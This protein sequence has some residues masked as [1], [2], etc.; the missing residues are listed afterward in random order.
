MMMRHGRGFA[1]EKEKAEDSFGT[2]WR[3]LTYFKPFKGLVVIVLVL[4]VV[5]AAFEVAAPYLIEVAVDQFIVPSGSEAPRWLSS[6]VSEGISPL[7]GLSR[8]MTILLGTYVFRWFS[9][10]GQGYLMNVMGQKVLFRMRTQILD[11]IHSLSLN[12]F[13][14][15]EAGDLMSRLVNDT[16]VINQVFTMGIVRLLSVSLNLIGIVVTMVSRKWDLALA[17]F[18]I[19]PVMILTTTIFAR[20]ARKAF[21][22]TRETIG[23]VSSELE[24]NISGV[25]EVQAFARERQNVAEFRQINRANR[26]ANVQAQTLT[27]AFS[28]TLDVLSNAAL[29]IVLGYGGWSVVQGWTSVGMVVG[30]MAYVQRFYRP[31]QM[32]SSLWTMFQSALAGAE[33]IFELLDTDPVVSDASDAQELA[34]AQGQIVFDHVDFYYKPEDPV[35]C[36]V[37]LVAEP[38]QTVALVGPTGAGKTSIVSLLMRFYDVVGGSVSV[39]GQDIRGVTQASLREQMGIV[40]QDT[41]LFSGTVMDNIR[42]GRLDAT[43]DEVIEASK[44]ANA[45][46]FVTRLP[47]EYNTD[48]GERGHNLSQGQ[49]QLISIARAILADPRILIL[50][51]ATSSVDTRTELLIQRALNELLHGRTSFVIAHRLSTIR[52]ADQVLFID[53]GEIVERGTHATLMEAGGKYHD[54]YMSQFRREEQEEPEPVAVPAGKRGDG[55][56]PSA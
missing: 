34:P 2:L 12:F 21:R 6:I 56:K 27:S 35:L 30:Y 3:L 9:M 23:E 26:D 49:R 8:V 51:E 22:K 46:D 48:I 31:I 40:L 50:D 18:A 13:D 5:N 36:D 37:S 47:E 16:Q 7:G 45:H 42:Y 11:R 55:S 41:F 38:G 4:L 33:R 29:A 20:R 39:D 19:L 54:L 25:R 32:L 53:Q 17:S 1:R 14:E 10:A 43:D 24:E 44:L 52:N 28:P 15:H